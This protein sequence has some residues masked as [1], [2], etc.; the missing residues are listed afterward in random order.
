MPNI[1]L[2]HLP[3]VLEM[4]ITKV[5]ISKGEIK[6]RWQIVLG[7]CDPTMRILLD[8]CH[9]VGVSSKNP[10]IGDEIVKF[11]ELLT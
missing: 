3:N 2:S 10:V 9:R 5:K 7:N 8:N 1:N 6:A 11:S 4:F